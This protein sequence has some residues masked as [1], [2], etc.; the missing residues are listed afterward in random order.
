MDFRN[1]V[2]VKKNDKFMRNNYDLLIVIH[3]RSLIFIKIFVFF[4]PFYI[5]IFHG[6]LGK[7]KLDLHL[8]TKHNDA[9]IL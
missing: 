7:R 9:L 3:K 1:F 5:S 4:I 2:L 8:M 6:I